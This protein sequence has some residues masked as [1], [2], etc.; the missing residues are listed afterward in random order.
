[1][2]PHW[3]AS[4]ILVSVHSFSDCGIPMAGLKSIGPTVQ[5]AVV[6]GDAQRYSPVPHVDHN[7]HSLSVSL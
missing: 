2:A 4:A 7:S 5:E 6:I 3:Q 1:V